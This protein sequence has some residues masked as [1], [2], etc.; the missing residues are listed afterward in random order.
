MRRR[1]S[2]LFIATFGI[3]VLFAAVPAEAQRGNTVS[4]VD[5]PPVTRNITRQPDSTLNQAPNQ[6]NDWFWEVGNLDPVNGAPGIAFSTTT[7]GSGWSFFVDDSVATQLN[8][9]IVPVELQSFSVE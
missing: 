7:P 2:F 5:Q 6:S 3:A 1:G 4:P 9:T 8:G